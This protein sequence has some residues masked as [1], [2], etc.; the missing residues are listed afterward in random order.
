MNTIKEIFL[1]RELIYSLVRKDLRGRYLGTSL[2][3]FWT[4][5][6]PLLQL[7]VYN[8]IFSIILRNNIEKY[9]L[10]LFIG[11][12]P[13]M[14]I[15]SCISSGSMVV[16]NEGALV[17]KTYFPREVLPIS[18]VTSG[19]INML[20]SFL[21]VF[22]VVFAS[23]VQVNIIAWLYLPVIMLVQYIFALGITMITSALTVYFRDLQH[24][25]NILQMAWM[26]LTP[27]MYSHTIVPENLLPIFYL[28][29]MTPI[30]VAYRDILYYARSPDLE[31]LAR[32]VFLG[33][34]FVIFGFL[35]FGRLKRGFAEE[36]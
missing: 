5:L 27:I 14:F 25:L 26:F 33:L 22:V 15:A 35:I 4:F 12:I 13:W 8:L 18:F 28:N 6:N 11:L 31:T 9:Y 1:Y 17:T 19:F 32:A 20:L 2:G 30:I 21:V 29:P 7:L 36:I 34:L 3:F 16:I 10:F 24:I 23:G